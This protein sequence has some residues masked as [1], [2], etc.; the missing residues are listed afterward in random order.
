MRRVDIDSQEKQSPM[1][2]KI[3]G[4]EKF[5]FWSETMTFLMKRDTLRAFHLDFFP[6]KVS[7]SLP[8][9]TLSLCVIAVSRLSLCDV[10]LLLCPRMRSSIS[11]ETFLSSPRVSFYQSLHRCCLHASELRPI[12]RWVRQALVK[13]EDET[14]NQRKTLLVLYFFALMGKKT[15]TLC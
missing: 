15:N 9:G 7:F 3:G 8:V 2:L 11:R 10:L 5:N 14:K 12:R 1:N 4:Y 6:C 13:R